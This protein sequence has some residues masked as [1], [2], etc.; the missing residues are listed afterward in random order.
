MPAK[1][2]P[3]KP[4]AT[5]VPVHRS[6]AG[7]AVK[8]KSSAVAKDGAVSVHPDGVQVDSET[9]LALDKNL[10]LVKGQCT[11]CHSSKL[12]LQSHFDREKWVERIRWMQRT[13]KL[14]DLGDTEPA[15]LTYLTKYYGPIKTPFDGRRLPLD[16]PK[17]YKEAGR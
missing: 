1:K 17:W 4:T 2:G 9:G 8:A 14:W 15:V 5:T 11:V 13:Q 6:P 3:S 7:K 16:A 12:I 10:M